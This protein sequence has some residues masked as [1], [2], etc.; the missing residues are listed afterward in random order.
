MISRVNKTHV[1]LGGIIHS[2]LI[3]WVYQYL[4]EVMESYSFMEFYSFMESLGLQS[5]SNLM[6]WLSAFFVSAIYNVFYQIKYLN[7]GK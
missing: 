7:I 2:F 1:S 5:P 4:I 6:M 3:V